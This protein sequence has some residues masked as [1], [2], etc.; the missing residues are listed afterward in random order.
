MVG[1]NSNYLISSNVDVVFQMYSY[2]LDI[3]GLSSWFSSE[4]SAEDAMSSPRWVNEFE[5]NHP[6]KTRQPISKDMTN[7]LHHDIWHHVTFTFLASWWVSIK[8]RWLIETETDYFHESIELLAYMSKV[9]ALH[10]YTVK[11][12]FRLGYLFIF[13]SKCQHN[14]YFL[15][16]VKTTYTDKLHNHFDVK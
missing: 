3:E 14:T 1:R 4:S 11:T 6:A 13:A 8:G 12:N 16:S 15:Q 10:M 5:G 2:L 7:H 9:C